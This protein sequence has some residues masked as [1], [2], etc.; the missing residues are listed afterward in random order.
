C[1]DPAASG[2]PQSPLLPPAVQGLL[3]AVGDVARASEPTSLAGRQSQ[4]AP[5][6]CVSVSPAGILTAPPAS[7]CE[8]SPVVPSVGRSLMNVWN[9]RACW[10]PLVAAVSL[11]PPGCQRTTGGLP[12]TEDT[13]GFHL[14]IRHGRG[15]VVECK[16]AGAG[17]DST[18][19]DVPVL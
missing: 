4:V 12:Y 15:G 16:P 10:V 14:S 8:P 3:K 19:G 9:V 18:E 6:G 2:Q 5:G 13:D 7:P 11:V 1:P 17:L